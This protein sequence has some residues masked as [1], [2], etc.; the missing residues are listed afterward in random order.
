M[1]RNDPY[2]N[3]RF[4]VNNLPGTII[5]HHYQIVIIFSLKAAFFML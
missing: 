2:R 1:A 4:L 5:R 3:M